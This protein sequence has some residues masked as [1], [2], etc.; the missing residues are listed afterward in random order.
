LNALTLGWLLLLRSCSILVL[1]LMF[2][3]GVLLQILVRCI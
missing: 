3:T 2:S 1:A